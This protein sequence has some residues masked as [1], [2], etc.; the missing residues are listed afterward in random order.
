MR[1]VTT[2]L[3]LR[4]IATIFA[5]ALFTAV[6]GCSNFGLSGPSDLD[7]QGQTD[8]AIESDNTPSDE[9]TIAIPSDI[10]SSEYIEQIV[11]PDRSLFESEGITIATAYA[12]LISELAFLYMQE[13]P[14]VKIN[15]IDYYSTLGGSWEDGL[16]FDSVRLEIATQLMADSAPTLICSLL[17]DSFDPRQTIFFYDWYKLMDADPN[18]NEEDWFMNVFHAFSMNDRLYQFP[19]TFGFDPVVV[20]TA[21]PGLMEAMSDKRQGVTMSELVELHRQFSA[22]FPNYYLEEYFSAE[23]LLQYS[24]DRFIDIEAG[25]VDFGEEFIDLIKYAES[26]TSPDVSRNRWGNTF[27]AGFAS[28]AAELRNSERFLFHFYHRR[29]FHHF[30]DHEGE[31]PFAG[32]TP[33]VN[34]RGELFIDPYN[35]FYFGDSYLLSATAT[36]IQKAIAWDFIMFIM[37]FEIQYNYS[38]ASMLMMPT[39]HR[40]TFYDHARFMVAVQNDG[41]YNW[42]GGTNEEAADGVIETM[43]GF[44]EMPMRRSRTLPRVIE[45]IISEA[46]SQFHDGLLSAEQVAELLQNQ[47]S[48]VLMEI[49][50]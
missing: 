30:L 15:I 5:A 7:N 36:P 6:V 31:R 21:I 40:D 44:L 17:A 19:I 12:Q 13:N 9:G 20:N 24:I 42:F 10:Y 25:V 39:L 18:F 3:C 8:P 47:V 48:I 16:V 38:L 27:P 37:Q 41:H 4:I 2:A 22:D 45:D 14:E 49:A 35:Y 32:I 50:Q 23:I 43:T 1:K 29:F 46:M 33:L 34:E 26:I 11:N 28:S